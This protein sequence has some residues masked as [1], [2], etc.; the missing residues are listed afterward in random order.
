[1]ID[2][3][4]KDQVKYVNEYGYQIFSQYFYF[5]IKELISN[6]KIGSI[7]EEE[8]MFSPLQELLDINIED[9]YEMQKEREE[10]NH[11]AKILQQCES[12][13]KHYY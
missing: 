1:M 7:D 11:D 6:L 9:S 8:P 13:V 10:F 2:G 5:Y 3:Y 4:I 12:I